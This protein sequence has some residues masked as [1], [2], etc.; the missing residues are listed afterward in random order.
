M[1]NLEDASADP[2]RADTRP[3]FSPEFLVHEVARILREHRVE[4]DMTPGRRP[5]AVIAAADLL[6][7]LGVH[8]VSAPWQPRR[9]ERRQS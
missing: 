1:N 6:R 7:A 5:V 2:L 8:P 4:V 9:N 3:T